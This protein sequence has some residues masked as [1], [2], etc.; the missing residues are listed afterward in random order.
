M[1][2][3]GSVFVQIGDE[4]VHRVRALM[5]EVFG[6]DNFCLR[7]ASKTTGGH[8]QHLAEHMRLHPVVCA[9]MDRR[10]V[11]STFRKKQS[12]TQERLIP[13]VLDAED[14]YAN[15]DRAREKNAGSSDEAD[16]AL[17]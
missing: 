12:M 1:T 8:R 3:S 11:S 13:I 7:Y 4:N 16:A 6:D 10:Q 9:R 14:S 5:D 2:D 17:V 15:P